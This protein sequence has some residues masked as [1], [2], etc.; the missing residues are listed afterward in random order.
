MTNRHVLDTPEL[1]P[2]WHAVH[3]RLSTGRPVS[4]VRVG[5]LGDAGRE[6]L[7][8]LLGLDRLPGTEPS[9]QLVHLE[10]AVADACGQSVREVAA[11]VIGRPI[12]NRSTEREREATERSLVWDWLAGHEV[13]TAQPALTEWVGHQQANGLVEGSPDRTRRLLAAALTVLAALPADGEPLPVLA[14]RL[15]GGDSHALDDGTRLSASV[16]RALAALYGTDV[17][18]SAEARRALWSRAGVADDELSST[19]LAVGL[20]PDGGGPVARICRISADAGHPVSLALGQLRSPGELGWPTGPVHIVE[21]PSVLA[22]ALRQFGD[23]CPPLVCTSGWPNTAVIHLLRQLAR[24]GSPLRHHGDF[25]GEGIRIAAH[26]LAKTG[27][28]PWRLAAGD[29]RAAATRLPA[30]PDPGRLTPAPWDP[31]LTLA[32]AE[33]GTAVVEEVVADVLLDDLRSQLR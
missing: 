6:A 23:R 5:P 27:A 25:D 32:M 12:T 4:R 30:G 7:A 14:A 13:V 1:R 18:D 28:V 15:L 20:R 2:L 22:L 24:S 33:L 21:N 19:V 8:D 29:Y 3:D 10:A 9:I 31:E 17:P 26:V 16:L 11:A